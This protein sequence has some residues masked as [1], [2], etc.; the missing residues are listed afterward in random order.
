MPGTA[1]GAGKHWESGNEKGMHLGVVGARV[2]FLLMRNP[3]LSAERPPLVVCILTTRLPSGMSCRNV[4]KRICTNTAVARGR[5]HQQ[6]VAR[7]HE[8]WHVGCG[9]CL[10]GLVVHI[11]FDPVELHNSVVLL[12]GQ[13]DLVVQ[14]GCTPRR[15]GNISTCD[16][17]DW[18]VQQHM[19]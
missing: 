16:S 18:A 14:L 19:V 17:G 12:R 7:W 5:T 15:T 2:P 11:A 10:G 6:G 1:V 9:P 4:K 13:V 3:A 8:A